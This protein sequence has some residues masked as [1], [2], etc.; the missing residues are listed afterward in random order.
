MLASY[1]KEYLA[2]ARVIGF[3]ATASIKVLVDLKER[4]SIQ[5]DNVIEDKNLKRSDITLKLINVNTL[6][7]VYRRTAECLKDI[8]VKR[9]R[10]LVFVKNEESRD[11]LF[12][13]LPEKTKSEI[14]TCL[15]FQKD[16][17]TAFAKEQRNVLVTSHDLGIGINLP[18]VNSCIHVG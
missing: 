18:N 14:D 17:Y 5:S 16:T 1:F 2:D 3:T 15:T 9:S 10:S 6:Q 13:A 7:H 12:E 11:S 8:L 4:L